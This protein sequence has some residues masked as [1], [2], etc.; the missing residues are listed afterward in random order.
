MGYARVGAVCASS[1]LFGLA[2]ISSAPAYAQKGR[3]PE[4]RLGDLRK[5]SAIA[6]DAARLACFD[7]AVASVIAQQDSGEITVVEKE[8]IE[9]TRRSLF[10]FSLPKIG[11]FGSSDDKA[12]EILQSRIT[13][14]RRVRND[15]WE[16]T[17]EEG[18]VWRAANTP[19]RFKPQV[20]DPVEL[21]AAAMGSFWFRVDGSH[22]V[23]ARRIR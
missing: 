9:T 20:G 4:D 10:G 13:G 15:Y 6:E 23:K 16:I 1:I 8:D 21:E 14:L 18:S 5:C 11:L 2:L 19:R 17:I 22:G 3:D 7:T 12:D